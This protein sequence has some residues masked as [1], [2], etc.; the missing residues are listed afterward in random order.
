MSDFAT[1]IEAF[2]AHL[3]ARHYSPRTVTDYAEDLRQ[4]L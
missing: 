3:R 2:L 4:L 1:A